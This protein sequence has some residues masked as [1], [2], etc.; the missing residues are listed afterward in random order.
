MVVWT[1]VWTVVVHGACCALCAMVLYWCI[2]LTPYTTRHVI[3]TATV[4]RLQKAMRH[5][6][7]DPYFTLFSF[8]GEE[9]W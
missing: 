7:L 6:L 1:V 5:P 9:E 8:F 3:G 4:V 2:V